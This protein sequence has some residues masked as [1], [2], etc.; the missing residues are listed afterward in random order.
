[1]KLRNKLISN[2]LRKFYFANHWTHAEVKQYLLDHF[3]VRVCLR[4]LKYWKKSLKDPVW[5]HPVTPTPPV[6]RKVKQSDKGR[7]ISLRKRTAWGAEKLIKVE[8]IDFSS[9]TVRRIIKRAGL[10]GGS[11]IE[12]KRIHWVK[13]QRAHPDS[14]WQIDSWQLPSGKW[15]IDIIDD[16]SRFCPG[17]C[18]VDSLTTDNLVLF[19]ENT[20]KIHGK[21]RE[22][23][24][25]NGAENGQK[26][27]ES[28]FDQWCDKTGIK[29][30]RSRVH[31]PTTAGKVERFH[32]TV[33]RELPYCN[34]DFELFRYRYNHIRPHAS[35]HMKTPAQVYFSLQTRLNVSEIKDEKW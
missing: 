3:S 29:H 23:L 24:T 7:V 16:C 1:M 6:Q 20:I 21:P 10:S 31:K 13:W 34:N 18:V 25:D 9:R 14:L 22:I 35:L 12:N 32:Q 8:K 26:S 28:K 5:Q 15:V 2:K 4:T 11:K 27:K 17:I 30:I 33:K 19:L